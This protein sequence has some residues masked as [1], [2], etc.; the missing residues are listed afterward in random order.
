MVQKWTT[1][2]SHFLPVDFWVFEVAPSVKS[3]TQ[4]SASRKLDFT[5]TR[6]GGPKV[7]NQKIETT[8]A[9]PTFRMERSAE[10]GHREEMCV[11][12]N[13]P[14]HKS[15]EAAQPA[16]RRSDGPLWYRELF[17][18]PSRTKYRRIIGPSVVGSGIRLNLSMNW[19]LL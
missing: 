18:Q 16:A 10:D 4:F 7:D 12:R 15:W 17:A 2:F 19:K 8:T 14:V 5:L 11:M 9:L 6:R 3:K 13:L 1:P